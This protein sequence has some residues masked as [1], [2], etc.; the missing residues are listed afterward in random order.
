MD[1]SRREHLLSCNV[2][3][4]TII[5]IVFEIKNSLQNNL[6]LAHKDDHIC[7]R[8]SAC[9]AVYKSDRAF[10]IPSVGYWFSLV[11]LG[12]LVNPDSLHIVLD[13][14]HH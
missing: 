12:T 3:L 6:S 8:E 7:Q 5:I 11:Q 1:P 4:P 2:I 13:D 10:S 14:L 9:K